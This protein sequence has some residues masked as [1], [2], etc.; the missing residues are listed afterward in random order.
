[1]Y[2]CKQAMSNS[3]Y[4][5]LLDGANTMKVDFFY[6]HSSLTF[7]LFF[8][9]NNRKTFHDKGLHQTFDEKQP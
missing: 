7:H 8:F 5:V 1:M 6:A 3:K 9:D 2:E 4:S